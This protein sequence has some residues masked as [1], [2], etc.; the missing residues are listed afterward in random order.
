MYE[1]IK[2]TNNIIE[3]YERIRNKVRKFLDVKGNENQ[4]IAVKAAKIINDE[5]F[6][7]F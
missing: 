5:I 6:N 3:N 2:T 1:V 7:T 4:K